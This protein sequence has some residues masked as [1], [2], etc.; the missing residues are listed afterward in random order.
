MLIGLNLCE[1]IWTLCLMAR[2]PQLVV[3]ALIGRKVS[4]SI[5]TSI[6]YPLIGRKFRSG[7]FVE[8]S[9]H[10]EGSFE[11]VFKLTS[12]RTEAKT[13]AAEKFKSDRN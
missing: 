6:Y 8:K 7:D 2:K 3:R 4:H 11:S 12:R 10:V 9:H 13:H 5:E 1:V